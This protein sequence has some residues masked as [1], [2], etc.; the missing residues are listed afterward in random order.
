MIA[1][2]FDNWLFEAIEIIGQS[3]TKS[4]TKLLKKYGLKKKII[5]YVK[6]EGFNFNAM[7]TALKLDMSCEYLS[8]EERFQGTYFGHVFSKACQYGSTK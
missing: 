3:F 1:K 6:D 7:T 4:L 2:A 8:L 5:V